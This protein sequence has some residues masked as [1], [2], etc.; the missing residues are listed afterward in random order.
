MLQ[1]L[2]EKINFTENNFL[3]K[4]FKL[5][6]NHVNVGM[7]QSNSKNNENKW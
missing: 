7:K 1:V 3:V 4:Q 2:L 6:T 5:K